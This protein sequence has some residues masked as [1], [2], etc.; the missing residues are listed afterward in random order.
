MTGPLDGVKVIDF[1]RVLAGPH[2]TKI[3]T[4]L[5]ASV[6]K[7]EDPKGGDISR[8]GSPKTGK[9]SHYF[10]QQ[11]SGKTCIS[12]D[13][14]KEKGRSIVRR[15][16]NDADVIA[17]NFRPGTLR[18]F[19]FDYETVRKI[20]PRIVYISISGYGQT[21]PLKSRAAFAPTVAAETGVARARFKHTSISENDFENMISDFSHPD[22]Y[23][24]IE[25]AVACLSALYSREKTG[26]GQ[27]VD[28]PMAATMLAVHEKAHAE[29][30]GLDDSEQGEP[31][32]L[33]APQSRFI[34][35]PSGQVVVIAANPIWTPALKRY[36]RMMRRWDLVSDSKFLTPELRRKNFKSLMSEITSWAAT[37]RSVADLEAQ[38]REAGLALGELKTMK[39]FA[40][41]EWGV[42]W[43]AIRELD[44]DEGGIIKVPGLPWKF[45]ETRCTPGS[46][47]ATRGRD[48]RQVL[49]SLGYSQKDIDHLYADGA[50]SEDA[51]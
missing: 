24:G 48:N 42:H 17:E 50:V 1:T 26:V 43:G 37:F 38:V 41:S 34:E 31:F 25:G 16:L 4:D 9:F 14:N 40:E 22:V 27:H 7:I 29:L 12:I 13:L 36:A 47:L 23:T 44:D 46:K 15:L 45:S 19:G 18:P 8:V 21:G 32:M 39:Q 35:I 3:L 28:V 6:I 10:A 11:N 30:A 5:G 33:T 2:F 51:D 49:E 20:N